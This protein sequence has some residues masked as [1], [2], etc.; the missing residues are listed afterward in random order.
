MRFYSLLYAISSLPFLPINICFSHKRIFSFILQTF[1]IKL[2]HD[3]FSTIWVH[4]H[5]LKWNRL[6]SL[7]RSVKNAN[8]M[9]WPGFLL[10]CYSNKQ[11]SF[12]C[13]AVEIKIRKKQQL[14]FHSLHNVINIFLS[15]W[16]FKLR[17]KLAI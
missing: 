4:S 7:V 14:E 16:N 6:A 2:L 5:N 10:L 3:T 9:Y 13:P 12:E 11:L 17:C 8:W 15:M 1:R